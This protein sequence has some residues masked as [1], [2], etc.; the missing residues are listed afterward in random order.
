MNDTLHPQAPY[1][2][3]PL[4]QNQKALGIQAYREP[5]IKQTQSQLEHSSKIPLP[6]LYNQRAR[7]KQSALLEPELQDIS[8]TPR[9]LS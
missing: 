4:W 3:T 5:E 7:G 9:A 8:Q 2:Q 1:S 6:V